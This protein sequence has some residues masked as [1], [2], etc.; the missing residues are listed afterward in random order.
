MMNINAP[1]SVGAPP[2]DTQ[3]HS[4]TQVDKDST[5][6]CTSGHS[7]IIDHV[8]DNIGSDTTLTAVVG[9]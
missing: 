8:I 2:L 4:L 3:P 9:K 6:Y 1:A 5:H 7:S